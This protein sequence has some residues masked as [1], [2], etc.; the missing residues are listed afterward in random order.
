MVQEIPCTHWV[1]NKAQS[2]NGLTQSV[3]DREWLRCFLCQPL[4]RHLGFSLP[5]VS[6]QAGHIDNVWKQART[7]FQAA[8]QVWQKLPLQLHLQSRWMGTQWLMTLHRRRRRWLCIISFF[9]HC[10]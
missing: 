6:N 8:A 9:F 7:H 5:I 3:I 2:Q 1:Q 4:V 10:A